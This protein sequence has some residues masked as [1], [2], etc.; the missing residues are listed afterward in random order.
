MKT[1]L[2]KQNADLTKIVNNLQEL[3]DKAVALT[4]IETGVMGNTILDKNQASTS[5]LPV[6]TTGIGVT[7][8][9]A[10]D[11]QIRTSLIPISTISLH[12][13]F[14]NINLHDANFLKY[15]PDSFLNEKQ[16]RAKNS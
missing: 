11:N 6:S 2:K 1:L 8:N 12:D 10:S 16:K 4:K 9:T 7:G 5:L 14:Q 3:L 13:L 15:V